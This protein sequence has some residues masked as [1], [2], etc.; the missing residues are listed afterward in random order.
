M[1]RGS[2]ATCRFLKH[3]SSNPLAT[4]TMVSERKD[5]EFTLATRMVGS[6]SSWSVDGSGKIT[7]T[8]SGSI[9]TQ[10]H[11]VD[12][13]VAGFAQRMLQNI[14]RL[15]S[16]SKEEEGPVDAVKAGTHG[17]FQAV[18]NN[19][20]NELNEAPTQKKRDA[21]VSI[22]KCAVRIAG[23]WG[24]D[25][26]DRHCFEEECNNADCEAYSD[27]QFS[28][29]GKHGTW[30]S[31]ADGDQAAALG[32]F[33]SWFREQ[34]ATVPGPGGLTESIRLSVS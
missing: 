27:D 22:R 14:E 6:R 34:N 29:Y 9:Q 12:L 20:K 8:T 30:S 3:F 23:G 31:Q 16:T 4:S 19:L 15:K 5:P 2:H 11:Q 21:P 18:L 28:E 13:G 24:Q 33:S 17:Y 7:I 26:H 10:T 1:N 25:A 32:Y